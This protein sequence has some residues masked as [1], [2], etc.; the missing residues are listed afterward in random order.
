MELRTFEME[1]KLERSID[2]DETEEFYTRT[3]NILS[4]FSGVIDA[5]PFT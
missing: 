1:G 3:L 2:S 4:W 5:P